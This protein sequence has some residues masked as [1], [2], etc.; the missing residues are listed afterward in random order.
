MSLPILIAA[1]LNVFAVIDGVDEEMG[2]PYQSIE[3]ELPGGHFAV[4]NSRGEKIMVHNDLRGLFESAVEIARYHG[5]DIIED[6]Q[7]RRIA[8]V[9]LNGHIFNSFKRSDGIDAV[10]RGEMGGHV[11]Y[12]AAEEL[13]SRS[14]G[15]NSPT[16]VMLLLHEI[17]HNY[18]LLHSEDEYS[19][20]FRRINYNM[21]S[22][23][24]IEKSYAEFFASSAFTKTIPL[25]LRGRKIVFDNQFESGLA[26]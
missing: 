17:G 3:E 9:S 22:Y 23:D 10:A 12:L 8:L 7:T 14:L 18:G 21:Y 20:M 25:E 11:I 6:A 16:N 19:V 4:T 24:E 13:Q 26:D 15:I 2:V 5:V 1:F